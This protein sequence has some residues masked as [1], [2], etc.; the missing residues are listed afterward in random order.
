MTCDCNCENC[1]GA[2]CC[3]ANPENT[4]I[5]TTPAEVASRTSGECPKCGTTWTQQNASVK[6]TAPPA[7]KGDT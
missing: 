4:D 1:N 7:S 2:D 3:C 6:V 5:I